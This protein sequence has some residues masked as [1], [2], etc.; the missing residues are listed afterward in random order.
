VFSEVV[1][2]SENKRNVLT[3]NVQVPEFV[4]PRGKACLARFF[5]V[6]YV[7]ICE[8]F[9]ARSTQLFDEEGV[10]QNE[11]WGT[12]CCSCILFQLDPEAIL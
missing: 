12:R 9:Y 3:L 10:L 2:V 4:A 11:Q 7:R 8:V 6:V 1:V 5:S